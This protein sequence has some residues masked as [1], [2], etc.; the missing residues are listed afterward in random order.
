MTH[1]PDVRYEEFMIIVGF[2][3]IKQKM[4][5]RRR[6]QFTIPPG[7][8]TITINLK[9]L[10]LF[11]TSILRFFFCQ[12][13]IYLRGSVMTSRHGQRNR[14]NKFKKQKYR[15]RNYDELR[16]LDHNHSSLSIRSDFYQLWF[17]THDLIG[18]DWMSH[19]R[20]IKNIESAS[21]WN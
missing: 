6:L 4:K 21:E 14:W 13:Q 5:Q 2:E 17:I 18:H 9:P 20:L 1:K 3:K 11:I 10:L 7:T 19:F 8:R 12:K 15:K 16:E